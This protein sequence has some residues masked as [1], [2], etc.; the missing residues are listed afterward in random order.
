MMNKRELMQALAALRQDA[1]NHL[2][3]DDMEKFNEV[4][5]EMQATREKIDAIEEI[6]GYADG[7]QTLELDNDLNGTKI[8]PQAARLASQVDQNQEEVQAFVNF[9][10]TGEVTNALRSSESE[11]GGF[12]V[13]EDISTRINEYKR[14]FVALEQYVTTVPVSLPSGSRVYEKLESMTPLSNITEMGEIPENKGPRFENTEYAV[15]DYAGILPLS[16]TLIRDTPENIIAHVVQWIAKKSVI[17]RNSLILGLLKEMKKTA[18]ASLDDV[19]K[20]FNVTLDPAIAASATVLT[21]Q[22]AFHEL[23][24]L[25]DNDGRYLLQDDPQDRTRK[26][27]KGRRVV[28]VSDA[29]LPNGGSTATPK[30]PLI[31]GD[32]KEAI[33]LFDRQQQ[34]ILTTQTGGKAFTRNTTDMRFIEREDVRMIDS[35]AAVY[36]E[37][38]DLAPAPETADTTS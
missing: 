24:V 13:P 34:E 33:T 4:R 21:N 36:L 5:K 22:S 10:K 18:A 23:D 17:T 7:I 31:V 3:N 8:D 35:G 1:E 30:F 28:V 15:K 20:A 37:F 2:K 27:F 12:L 19:K 9:M 25:K 11:E 29:F 38:T 6:D 14:Q 32:L 16:N 26:V